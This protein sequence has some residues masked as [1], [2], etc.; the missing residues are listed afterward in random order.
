MTVTPPMQ[1]EEDDPNFYRYNIVDKKDIEEIRWLL[2]EHQKGKVDCDIGKPFNTNILKI[3]LNSRE[4]LI[5]AIIA[6]KY[7]CVVYQDMI[8]KAIKSD[9]FPFIFQVYQMNINYEMIEDESSE[10]ESESCSDTEGNISRRES[11]NGNHET[12]YNCFTYNFLL[13]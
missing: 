11:I 7:K 6:H 13:R 10:S 12:K 3:A 8:I 2:Q 4:T 5:A 9:Q 1:K